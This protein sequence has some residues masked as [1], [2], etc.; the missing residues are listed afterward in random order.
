MAYFTTIFVDPEFD[1]ILEKKC[2][3]GFSGIP[4][5]YS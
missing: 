1:T 2:K 3:F 4:Y 5:G